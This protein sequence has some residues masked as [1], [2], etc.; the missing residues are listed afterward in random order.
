MGVGSTAMLLVLK[1][2]GIRP[3]LILFPDTSGEKPDLAET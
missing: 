3:D 2:H 1:V